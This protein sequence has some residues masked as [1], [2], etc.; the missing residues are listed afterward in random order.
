MKK[1]L[2]FYLTPL[3]FAL[4]PVTV[5][6]DENNC[7]NTYKAETA[8]LLEQYKQLDKQATDVR[9]RQ[10]KAE[11][12]GEQDALLEQ[13]NSLKKA[14]DSIRKQ[15]DEATKRMA[16]CRGMPTS[17][18]EAQQQEKSMK[19]RIAKQ[20][21]A[22]ESAAKP[23]E[24]MSAGSS[25]NSGSSA[26][27]PNSSA[28][29]V[30]AQG[31]V[32]MP[33][34][35]EPDPPTSYSSSAPSSGPEKTKQQRDAALAEVNAELDRMPL[36]LPQKENAPSKSDILKIAATRNAS[37]RKSFPPAD[38]FSYSKAVPWTPH[39]DGLS[40]DEKKAR[41]YSL[42]VSSITNYFNR[43]RLILALAS[44]VF[45]LDPQSTANANNFASAIVTAGERLYPAKTQA[46]ELAP[47][48]KDAEICFLYAM[49][50]SMK[51]DAWTDESL[52]AIINLGNLYMDMGKL[53]EARSLFQAARKQSPFSWDAALGMA[54]Y[55]TAIKQPGKAQALLE[56]DNLDRPQTLMVA[57]KHAK[58]L[59]KSE[60][61]PPDSPEQK[62]EQNIEAINSEP[63]ATAAD[64]MSQIDQSARNKLRYFV[65][66]LPPTGSFKAPLINKLTQYASLKAIAAPPGI[67][68]L[69]DFAQMLQMYSMSSFAASSDEQLKMLSRLG[70]DL[71]TG[72][73]LNDVAKHPE[74]YA[75]SKNRPKVKVDKQE[76]MKNL[77]SL[78]RQAKT[79]ERELATGKTTTLTAMAAQIDP[80]FTILQI[81]PQDYADPMNIIVQRHNFAVYNRKTNLYTGYLHTVNKKTR[82][83]FNDIASN[84]GR[85]VLEAEKVQAAALEKLD[86][87]GGSGAGF[88]LQKHNVHIH[89]RNTCNAAAE[90]AFGSATNV[91]VTAY[92]GKIKPK[93][94]AY[95]YDVIRHVA[96][97]SDPEVRSR[98]DSELRRAIHSALVSALST[99][100]AAHG[101]FK[102]HPEWECGCNEGNLLRE[103]E[104]ELAAREEEENERLKR[105]KAA[106]AA[107]DSG[108]IPDSTPLFK[109]L[110]A[111]GFDFDYFFFK[112]RMS[113]AYTQVEFDLTIP[114]I[115]G[116]PQITLGQK[117]SEFTGA[118]TYDQ[119]IK[120][121]IKGGEGV[122]AY[123]NLSSS[124]TTDGQGEVKDYSVTAATGLS[125]S[126]GKTKVTVNG[127]MTFGPN[128]TVRD[129]DFSAGISQDF[130]IGKQYTG[131]DVSFTGNV[132]LEASTKRGC[133]LTGAV[134]G[135]LDKVKEMV[136]ETKKQAMMDGRNEDKSNP[137]AQRE[138]E[139]KQAEKVAEKYGGLIP[140][141]DFLQK[142]LWSR[143]FKLLKPS[144][145]GS[146]N[147]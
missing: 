105:N 61:V 2:T 129:S 144:N 90:T 120:V 118:G 64:F 24:N 63:I 124:V 107:F 112:G 136:D 98:K 53:E 147:E 94:E 4:L 54:A 35:P 125:V 68:A 115:P 101:S 119:G 11:T 139:R 138:A 46:K 37:A 51:G 48:R 133:S 43:P 17:K 100:G 74:K 81:D 84:Y 97:I 47:Y 87:S 50:N 59:E 108:E 142:S 132:S 126:A 113:C 89:Y 95:Y 45:S 36:I 12:R 73:D 145:G 72:V 128:G 13:V 69:R 5:W 39:F 60:D 66:N 141:D 29:G 111:Y 9:A 49:A 42:L 28:M 91:A 137:A 123:V 3:L 41:D 86:K 58:A 15:M 8:P 10:N 23:Y 52:T 70:L 56:D 25:K 127:Q 26:N 102:Y 71:K 80:F 104:A 93:A 85:K 21:E 92:M 44:A 32:A 16:K 75:N 27:A 77:E 40:P 78:R 88:A 110:D 134:E 122:K 1:N 106:K 140:T 7:L 57:K 82:Q 116:A 62:Y 130:P 55:F 18:E 22:W 30:A 67:S 131:T 109:K 19:A 96:L 38:L 143:T 99:V 121:S 65:E 83:A 6:A 79:A 14:Q 146:S 114:F 103:R 135:S 33:S 20:K 76:L 117:V 31:L 34:T